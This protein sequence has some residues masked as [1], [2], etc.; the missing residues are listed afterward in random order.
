MQKREVEEQ[1][2]KCKLVNLLGNRRLADSD[3]QTGREQA[4]IQKMVIHK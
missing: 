1:I 2:P 4:K 3:N